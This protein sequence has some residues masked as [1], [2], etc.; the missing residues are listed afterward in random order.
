MVGALREIPK[1]FIKGLKDLK[2]KGQIETIQT[3]A[4]IRSPEY[5]VESGRV[6]ETSC[7]SNSREKPSANIGMKKLTK[8]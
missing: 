4:L 1:A 3:M 8:K 5:W 6:E 2:I 7:L